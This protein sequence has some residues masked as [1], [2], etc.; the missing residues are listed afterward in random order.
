MADPVPM[1]DESLCPQPAKLRRYVRVREFLLSFGVLH[2]GNTALNI[3]YSLALLL[4]VSRVLPPDRYAQIVFFTAI[5]LYFQPLDQA[6]GRVLFAQLRIGVVRKVAD[7][8]NVVLMLGA[9]LVLLSFAA[10]VIPIAVASWQGTTQG[11][12]NVAGNSLYLF[13]ALLMNFWAFDL[14]STGFALDLSRRFVRWSLLHRLC[15]FGALGVLWVTADFNQFAFIAAALFA[16]FTA[17]ACACISRHVKIESWSWSGKQWEVRA[18]S[19]G[20]SLMSG[21]S[22]LLAL[23]LPYAVIS[24]AYGVGSALVIF[25][26]VMK[27]AR[28][29]MAGSRT[30][31]EI[32]LP[33]HSRLVLEQ[34][35]ASAN[36]L[37]NQIVMLCVAA[38][39]IPAAVVMLDAS[40]VFSLLLGPNNVVP[41]QAGIATGVIILAT[42]LYQPASLLMSFANDYV[43][44]RRFTIL[45]GVLAALF[46]VAVIALKAGS[47]EILWIYAIVLTLSG[48]GA[49]VL[50]QRSPYPLVVVDDTAS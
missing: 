15:Q 41:A 6:L 5:S 45:A 2:T 39:A 4:V 31:T 37:F 40:F 22:D 32:G 36:R 13:F 3:L 43:A 8:Q 27:L 47:L 46:F 30:L 12:T 10:I 9:Q 42:G 19:L 1:T 7:Q 11:T 16:A 24:I 20:T 21:L 25:D 49:V 48:I 23:N 14:Q 38:S 35:T 29:T 50:G 17:F 33:R 34:D 26:T 44:I 18:R 28:L